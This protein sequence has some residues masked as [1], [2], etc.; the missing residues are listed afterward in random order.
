MQPALSILYSI[1]SHNL[2]RSS[3]HH[4]WIRNNPFPSWPV[5]SYHSGAGKVHSS[6]LFD[7]VF[8]PRLL[9]ASFS[10]FLSLCP[11]PGRIAQSVGHLTRKPKIL[12]SIPGLAT[13]FRLKRIR[14]N[15][16]PPC[17]VFSCPNWA[18]K[19]HS[20]PHFDIVF[21]PFLSVF[22]LCP[23][24]LSLLNQKTLRHGLTILSCVSWPGSGVHN[25]LQ[26]LL[27]SFYEPPHW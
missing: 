11:V 21:P 24:R 14:N 26:W 19:V 22:S 6:P 15:S 25:I 8:P 2:G 20:C 13:Y 16:Y 1:L 4:R 5:F 12:G 23:V 10:F 7:I 9:A 18:G 17:P 3:G 27:G